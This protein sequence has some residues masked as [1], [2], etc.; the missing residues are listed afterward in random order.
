VGVEGDNGVRHEVSLSQSAR[1]C[2]IAYA[3]L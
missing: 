2:Q 3:G 1:R